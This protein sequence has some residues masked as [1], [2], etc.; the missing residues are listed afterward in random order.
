[1]I[2]TKIVRCVSCGNEITVDKRA[3]DKKC[4]CDACRVQKKIKVIK[5]KYC[6]YCNMPVHRAS[7]FCS[8][9]C[10]NDY[11]FDTYIN[12]WKSGKVSGNYKNGVIS[13]RVRQY[14]L[15]KNK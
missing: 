14:V 12:E 4:K 6:L 10:K 11:M 5:L 1:M 15:E 9:Q 3:S 13:D 7:K 8:Q 2:G